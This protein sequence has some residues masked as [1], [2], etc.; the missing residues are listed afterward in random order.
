[1][2][3]V[4]MATAILV[5]GISAMAALGAIMLTRGRQSRYMNVA[6]TLASEKLEDLNR[7]Q[8][9]APQ[10]CI[11]TGDTSE[12]MLTG[13]VPTPGSDTKT[14]TCPSGA[15]ASTSYYDLVSID[16]LSSA[17]CANPSYGCFSE[18]VYNGPTSQ[19]IPTYHSPDGT[20]GQGTPTTSIPSNTTFL[21]TWLIEANPPVG[22]SGQNTVTGTRRIT[23]LVTN[24]DGSIQ[25]PVSFQMSLVRQ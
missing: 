5:I 20:I 13:V 16:F 1:M 14:I 25:P 3:E 22:S 2:I 8:M 19:Y 6:A 24:L 23:V 18:T 21:R 7:Y 15:S 11:Q 17:D 4:M 10:I 9:S 12:G